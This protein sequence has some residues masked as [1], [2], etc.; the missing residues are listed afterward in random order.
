MFD[1]HFE[2][3][4]PYVNEIPIGLVLHAD[5]QLTYL[6]LQNLLENAQKFTDSGRI[7]IQAHPEGGK[8]RISVTD[9]GIGFDENTSH[10]ILCYLPGM[11]HC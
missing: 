8:A 5:P 4:V 3:G 11:K 1:N 9:T 7:T 6:A 10:L 2:H